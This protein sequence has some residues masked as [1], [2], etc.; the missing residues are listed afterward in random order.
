[1][2]T[3]PNRLSGYTPGFLAILHFGKGPTMT[4]KSFF[5]ALVPGFGPVAPHAGFLFICL[6]WRGIIKVARRWRTTIQL[7]SASCC[8]AARCGDSPAGTV[9]TAGSSGSSSHSCRKRSGRAEE[10][11]GPIPSRPCGSSST[12]PHCRIHLHCPAAHGQ[13]HRPLGT[14]LKPYKGFLHN[15]KDVL[16][17]AK[18]FELT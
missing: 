13:E 17:I 3:L 11:S 18:D 6:A 16:R 12:S 10:C 8:T 2:P 7:A 15:T 9:C 1:M 4:S 14:L 5:K